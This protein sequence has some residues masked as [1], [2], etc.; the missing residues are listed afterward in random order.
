MKYIDI[1]VLTLTKLDDTFPTA[2]FLMKGF[3]EPCRLDRNRNG[4]GVMIYIYEEIPNKLLDKHVFPYDMEG[5]FVELSFRESKWL[6]FE[7]YH[8]LYQVEI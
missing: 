5:L 8:P 3:S 2:E 7:A 4:G 6:L 1:L